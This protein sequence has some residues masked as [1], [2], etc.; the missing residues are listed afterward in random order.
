M[1]M[2]RFSLYTKFMFVLFVVENY[3][4]ANSQKRIL[5]EVRGLRKLDQPTSHSN[6]V[7][8][9][10]SWI[11]MVP[12]DDRCKKLPWKDIDSETAMLVVLC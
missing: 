6:I 3:Y 4:R 5:R 7:R 11:D 1:F 10:G 12:T 8:Y 2:L 9:Y